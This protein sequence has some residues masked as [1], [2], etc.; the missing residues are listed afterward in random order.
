M[1]GT[2]YEKRQALVDT[3]LEMNTKINLSAIR[4]PEWV[5]QKH[6][7]DSL[8]ITKVF[9]FSDGGSCLDVG[10]GWGFPLLPLATVYPALQW[11]WLDA[12]QKKCRAVEVM[13]EQLWLNNVHLLR[14]RAE[15]IKGSYD[16]VTSRAVA[17][18]DKLSPWTIKFAKPW[19]YIVR[20]KMRTE[21]EDLFITGEYSKRKVEL[22]AKHRYFLEND[23][24]ER[25][26]YIMRKR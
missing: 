18:A 13:A 11:Y 1:Q 22:E 6:I 12:T 26:L 25:V 4:T 7:Q 5:Y 20:W 17:Y 3:F 21:E 14:W 2:D 10:T 15:E 9:D 24:I 8:E 16:L 19:W 23:T